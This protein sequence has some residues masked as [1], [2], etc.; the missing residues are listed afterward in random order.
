MHESDNSQ[1]FFRLI[2]PLHYLCIINGLNMCWIESDLN[3]PATVTPI[4]DGNHVKRGKTAH[5]VTLQALFIQ[6]QNVF[7]Q[8]F[9]E[10]LKHLE[11]LLRK[12]ADVCTNGKKHEVREANANLMRVIE[13]LR[14]IEKMTT[15]NAAQEK[16]PMFK[17]MRQYLRIVMEMLTFIRAVRT[18]DWKLHLKALELFTMFA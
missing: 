12:L 11:E 3:G 15:F 4:L 14:I 8:C 13:S 5:L 2:R 1:R 6:Y 7:F 18:G 16:K 9:R 10:E 17:V